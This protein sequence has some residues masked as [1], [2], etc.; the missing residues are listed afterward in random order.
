VEQGTVGAFISPVVTM[1]TA[2]TA[3]VYPF[4]FRYHNAVA[5]FLNRRSPAVLKEYGEYLF[6]WL[7]TLR[8]TFHFHS[9]HARRVQ[10]SVRLI[11][12]NLGII[13][14]LIALGTGLLQFTRQIS[15]LILLE[16]NLL[17]L[18][19]GG[20][21]LGL[22]VPP[23]IHIWRCLRILT[24]G[25]AEYIWPGR[26]RSFDAQGRRDL[27]VVVRDTI[28]ILVLVVPVV[29]SIPFIAG[30]LSLGGLVAP[31]PILLMIGVSA[32]LA[33]AAFQIHEVLEAT[34]SRTFLGIDDPHYQDDRDLYFLDDDAHL[35]ATDNQDPERSEVDS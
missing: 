1:V 19:I 17:G 16:E 33:L 18:I 6:L 28:L 10:H 15:D 7:A 12:L 20:A 2:I 31:L 22:C 5:D 23:A 11:M 26:T 35:H 24:D 32:G 29:L 4:I 8:S 14:F 13:I 27:R 3:L 9:P 21:V 34:F 30:L 25:V